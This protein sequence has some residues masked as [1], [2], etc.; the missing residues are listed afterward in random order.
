MLSILQHIQRS[1]IQYQKK[2]DVTHAYNNVYIVGGMIVGG[3]NKFIKEILQLFPNVRCIN[4]LTELQ[5]YSI[6]KNDILLIQ[7][8]TSMHLTYTLLNNLYATTK[9]RII[10][11]IHDFCYFTDMKT[12]KKIN[13]NVHYAYLHNTNIDNSIKKLFSNA[14]L[15]IHPSQFTFTQYS[16]YFS[17]HNFVVSP[18]IDYTDLDSP[19]SIPPIRNRTINVGV[20]HS[21]TEYKG[22]EYITHLKSVVK[23]HANHI[24]NFLIVG[25]NIEAYGE[26]EFFNHLT[27]YNIHCLTLLNKW[28]ETYCYTLS[29]YLKSG[30][31]ILYT[32]IG[33]VA[34][35]MPIKPHYFTAFD[36]EVAFNNTD[37]IC[38]V[39]R[40]KDMIDFVIKTPSSKLPAVDLTL[41][42]PP[43]YATICNNKTTPEDVKHIVLISSAIVVSDT[44]LSY[45]KQ[46]SKFSSKERFEQTLKTI[47]SVR[48]H[49][50][51]VAILLIDPTPIPPL[52]KSRLDNYIDKRIDCSQ[53]NELIEFTN[54]CPNKG[55]AECKQ[56]LTGL[57]HIAEYPNAS[58]IFKLSGRYCLTGSFN[59]A[60]FSDSKV[61]FKTVPPGSVFYEKV[62]A[63]YTFLY[64]VPTALIEEYKNA[65]HATVIKGISSLA[66]I[67][68]ILPYEFGTHHTVYNTPLGVSAHI[69]PSGVFLNNIV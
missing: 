6:T 5:A 23:K 56:L 31:P 55:V 27:R 61:C 52:W 8:L 49:I 48:R 33:A 14:E 32:N 2:P 29:K 45:T 64:S 42:I 3:S 22:K 65:L 34:E 66:S 17:T 68:T 24:I 39:S 63:C 38:L 15:V 57:N 36:R 44:P 62:P 59:H 7:H 69:G 1:K 28:G 20:L 25:V 12:Q 16:K 11:N 58:I 26:N 53:D 51:N 35:R 47:H 13:N 21:F 54:T 18:H 50:P 40:F 4:T 10:I 46:R 43:L 60:R 41:S 67:E 9:P 37:K 30:L 19:L